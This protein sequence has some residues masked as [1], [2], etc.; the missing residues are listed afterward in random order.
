[1]VVSYIRERLHLGVIFKWIG[2]T[3]SN[4]QV[5]PWARNGYKLTRSMHPLLLP[6]NTLDKVL[7][8]SP[9]DH[10][11]VGNHSLSKVRLDEKKNSYS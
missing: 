11:A 7:M 2:R 4:A 3:R 5:S 9:E 10:G 8:D 6:R 1:M